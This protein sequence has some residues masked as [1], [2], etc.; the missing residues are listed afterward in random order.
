ML[1]EI[2]HFVR[3]KFAFV[4][5]VKLAKTETLVE[6]GDLEKQKKTEK[7]KVL[8]SVMFVSLKELEKFEICKFLSE[9]D[10]LVMQLIFCIA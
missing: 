7:E 2:M 1:C 6:I 4:W 3:E 8:G 5:K 10:A 9:M